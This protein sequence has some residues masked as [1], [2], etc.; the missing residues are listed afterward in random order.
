MHIKNTKF[1]QVVRYV[2]AVLF[3]LA[4]IG[5][6]WLKRPTSLFAIALFIYG[7]PGHVD[8]GNT[9]N[10]WLHSAWDWASK[11]FELVSITLPTIDWAPL[12]SWLVSDFTRWGAL[13]TAVLLLNLDSVKTLSTTIAKLVSKIPRR[14][15]IVVKETLNRDVWLNYTEAFQVVNNSD[16]SK[17]IRKRG[18]DPKNRFDVMISSLD[19]MT[20]PKQEAQSILYKA[21][22]RRV[23]KRYEERADAGSIRT[24]SEKQYKKA[25]LESYLDEKFEALIIENFGAVE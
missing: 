13:L 16:W 17:Y 2:V 15:Q 7:V 1:N 18:E 8:D 11:Q 25:D 20:N 24:D 4:P 10:E 14:T 23:L 22:I 5:W 19:I 9:W 3:R 12:V 21:W 6:Q